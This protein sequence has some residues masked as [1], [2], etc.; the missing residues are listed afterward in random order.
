MTDKTLETDRVFF[1]VVEDLASF[2]QLTTPVWVFDVDMHKMWWANQSA[3]SFWEADSVADLRKR[4]FSTDSETV[5]LRL[6]QVVENPGSNGAIQ[7][8]WTLYPHELPTT[9]LLDIRPALIDSG[10]NAVIIEVVS[11]IDLGQNPDSLRILEAA[12]SS[13]ILVSTF[14]YSGQLLSQN[15]AANDCYAAVAQTPDQSDLE[16]R[17]EDRTIGKTILDA[18]KNRGQFQAELVVNTA[19]GTRIHDVY[20]GKGR[21]PITGQFVTVLNE[22]DRTEQ[23]TLRNDLER[24]NDELE[25]RVLERTRALET[26]NEKLRLEIEEREAMEEKLRSAERMEAI[27]QLTGGIAH[28]FNNILAVILGN[29]DLLGV[30]ASKT[31]RARES[32]RKAVHRAAE[33]TE[34]LLVFARKQRLQPQATSPAVLVED[35]VVL[36]N[37]TLGET[38]QITTKSTAGQWAALADPGQLENALLNIALNARDAM[39]NGGTLVI[40][41]SN[42]RLHETEQDDGGLAAGDYVVLAVRD[43]GAG[44]TAEVE[45]RVFEPFYTS[46]E[47]GQGSG[48]GL[49]M[50]YGFAKQSGGDVLIETVAGSGTTVK[51]YLPRSVEVGHVAK[52]VVEGKILQ[53]HGET[54]LLIEDNQDLLKITE[55]MLHELGYRVL[56]AP[57]AIIAAQ[58]MDPKDKIDIVLSDIVLPNGISG[59]EFIAQSR[60]TNPTL[61]A[62]F[63]SGYPR[64]TLEKAKLE[65]NIEVL[66]RKP[67]TR[68]QLSGLLRNVLES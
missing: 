49:S 41:C 13:A 4:D 63:M 8:T 48:L 6:K 20:A 26:T 43:T 46:K 5:R 27:G 54:V 58:Y 37:R 18:V 34:R 67:F 32:I 65:Q 50:V 60:Q 33:L 30:E 57:D 64:E 45:R 40:E 12:R 35:V 25:S 36:L 51:L 39:P 1:A 53:G 2:D 28:D 23:A 61:K 29:V 38:I 55:N 59:P 14:S 66:L 56:T 17:F 16:R 19:N 3:L 68:R 11:V 22:E 21:D 9:I 52:P 44:M 24:L 47:V 15:P 7:E 10:R 62:I 31:E 42:L